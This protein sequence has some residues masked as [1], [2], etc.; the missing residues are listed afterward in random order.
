M[1]DWQ[2]SQL[3]LSPKGTSPGEEVAHG[4]W[5]M[6]FQL[7]GSHAFGQACR[8][9]ALLKILNIYRRKKIEIKVPYPKQQW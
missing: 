5:K 7:E 2:H 8:I 4:H 3:A 6:D 1:H 9:T